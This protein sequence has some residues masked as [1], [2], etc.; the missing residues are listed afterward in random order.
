[1]PLSWPD[2]FLD[3]V[4]VALRMQPDE[5]APK[6]VQP[7]NPFTTSIIGEVGAAVKELDTVH[8]GHDHVTADDVHLNRRRLP[9]LEADLHLIDQTPGELLPRAGKTFAEREKFT[10]I[11]VGNP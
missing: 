9:L 8:R 4:I 10:Q 5:V 6:I 2:P 1:M 7:R 11:P 3:R